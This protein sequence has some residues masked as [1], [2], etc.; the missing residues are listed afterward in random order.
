MHGQNIGKLYL[1]GAGPGDPELLTLKAARILRTCDVIVYDR[2]VSAEVLSF[3]RSDAE[4]IY[5]GKHAGEQACAQSRIFELIRSRASQGK[6]IARLKGGDPLVFGRG[7]E[8]WLFALDH[9]IQVELIP[10]VTSAVSVPGLAGIPLTFRGVSESFA[11]ITGH[12]REGLAQEWS[13]YAAIDTLIIL[14]GAANRGF[15]A[16]GLIAAGRDSSQPVAFIERGTLDYERI[17]ES[18]LAAVAAGEVEV[19]SP[20]V[21]VIG[22][23]VR[24][25]ELLVKEQAQPEPIPALQP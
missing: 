22:E 4:R 15:I 21:F 16:K 6:T 14:M 12:C 10:G 13:K 3:A 8:E 19:T 2:L 25:R 23:V 11:V 24:L 1:I 9:G 18:T 17:I 7:A 20:A 5:A